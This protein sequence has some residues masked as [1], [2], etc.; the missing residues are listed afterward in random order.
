[1]DLESLE[2]Q[3][4][5]NKRT[6]KHQSFALKL[7]VLLC[8]LG[9]FVGVAVPSTNRG[10]LQ[11]KATLKEKEVTATAGVSSTSRP[12]STMSMDWRAAAVV[13]PA[14]SVQDTSR[15]PFGVACR[16]GGF[17]QM[18]MAMGIARGIG[19]ENWPKVTHLGGTS[20]GYWFASQF[21]YSKEFYDNV[22]NESKPL[23]GVL[24]DWGED[25]AH[26]PRT[27]SRPSSRLT[28]RTGSSRTSTGRSQRR[29]PPAPRRSSKLGSRGRSS[30][31]RFPDSG[32]SI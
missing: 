3:T 31:R 28:T 2:T 1:M 12:A 10:D 8:G 30:L 17:R 26:T 15:T 19:A 27:S 5:L 21:T 6:P 29:K 23:D 9:L 22:L 16:G 24:A 18:T 7:A 32:L 25:F 13:A 4:L 14:W 11:G 20:G